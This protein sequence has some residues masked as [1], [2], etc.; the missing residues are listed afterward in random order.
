MQLVLKREQGSKGIMS[1]SVT[2]IL[3]ARADLSQEEKHNVDRY[4][5]G[6]QV[7]YN[8]EASQKHLQA[9]RE[10]GSA[11]GGIARLALAKMSLNVTINSLMRGQQVTCSTL[12]EVLGAEEAMRDACA[13]LKQYLDVAETFD[14]RQEVI[15]F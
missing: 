3:S 7:I 6:D 15:E 5:L 10:S 1:K 9:G 2:F 13:A 14:G 8:S 4:K 11:L 12:D